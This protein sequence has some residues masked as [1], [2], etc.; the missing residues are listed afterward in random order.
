MGGWSVHL[1]KED[2]RR[3]SLRMPLRMVLAYFTVISLD[4]YTISY[5]PTTILLN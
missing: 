1:S 4:Y 3:R 5:Y 2:A